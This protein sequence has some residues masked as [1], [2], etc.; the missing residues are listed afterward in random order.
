[1]QVRSIRSTIPPMKSKV[2]GSEAAMKR[3]IM[4]ANTGKEHD[5]HEESS[6]R[7]KQGGPQASNDEGR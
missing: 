5:R 7:D 6:E 3:N 4:A 1:M 2:M